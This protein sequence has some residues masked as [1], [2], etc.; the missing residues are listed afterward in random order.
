M[1]LTSNV[2]SL[3]EVIGDAGLQFDPLDEAA[4]AGALRQ[5][6]TLTDDAAAESRARSRRR[7]E[8]LLRRPDTML[9]S[10]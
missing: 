5:A 6:V 9:R 7:A 3:P 8:A 10:V 4:I 2:S 1:V